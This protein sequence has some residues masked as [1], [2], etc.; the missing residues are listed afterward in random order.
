MSDTMLKYYCSRNSRKGVGGGGGGG[1][2]E[3]KLFH[4]TALWCKGQIQV[5]FDP[6]QNA[7]LACILKYDK[8]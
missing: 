2:I 5:E 1:A 4:V 8:M 3:V 7:V 6:A